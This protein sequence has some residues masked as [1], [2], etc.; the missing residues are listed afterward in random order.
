[1]T[2]VVYD[3]TS[4]SSFEAVDYWVE[5]VRRERGSDVILALVGNKNDLLDQRQVTFEE[6]EA[7]AQ[8]LSATLFIEASAKTGNNVRSLFQQI[9]AALGRAEP[10]D[11]SAAANLIDVKLKPEEKG[12]G[13][14]DRS[15]AC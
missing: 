6:G 1:V 12:I 8:L 15:C 2:V 10:V 9:A 11:D 13:N 5:D 3:V 7:K 4:R 14:G